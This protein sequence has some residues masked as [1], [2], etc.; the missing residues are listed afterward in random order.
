MTVNGLFANEQHGFQPRRSCMTQLM[1]ATEY[2]TRILQQ[3]DSLDII[4]LDFKKAFDSVPHRR[5]LL[6]LKQYGIDG[7][8]LMWIAAF[9][10]GR[11]LMN[12]SYSSCSDVISGIPQGSFLGP[13]LFSIYIN[14]LPPNL[15]NP[16]M[17]FVNDTNFFVVYQDTIVYQALTV[18]K[19]TLIN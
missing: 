4:Y 13:V 11:K 14:D 12:N 5:L 7:I 6:K 15:V 17:L 18:F 1:V 3:G 19:R 16:T 10:T 2:W 9:H 8:L